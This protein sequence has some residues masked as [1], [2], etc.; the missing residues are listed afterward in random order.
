MKKRISVSLAAVG[1]LCAMFVLPAQA[2]TS[3]LCCLEPNPSATPTPDGEP[4][5]GGTNPVLT[6]EGLIDLE[7]VEAFYDGGLGGNGSGPGP[8]LG[9]TF[10]SNGLAIISAE[11]PDGT[12]NFTNNPSGDTILFFL[13]G[14][15]TIMNVPAGFTDGFS[16]FYS[17]ASQ[18]GTV[19]VYDGLDGTGTLLAE[20]SLPITPPTGTTPYTFDNWQEFG[21][22]FSGTALSVDFAGTADQIGFDNITLGSSVPGGGGGEP[23][24]EFFPVPVGGLTWA[25]LLTLVLM[26]T[27]IVLLRR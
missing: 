13:T 2:Q 17:A 22:S 21:A 23:F 4:R 20:L 5:G 24:P 8:D 7:P 19:R 18:P 1:L 3:G 6:F 14:T 26:I 15:E 10:S 25:I 9:I 27:G 11:S 16:F 12:G